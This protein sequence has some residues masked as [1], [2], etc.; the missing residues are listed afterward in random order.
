MSVGAAVTLH[1]AFALA[2]S[3]ALAP[4]QA[5]PLDAARAARIDDYVIAFG[6][7]S[8]LAFSIGLDDAGK[9][10]SLSYG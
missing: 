8:R 6:P 3:L 9:L 2:F 1:R 7:G 5:A 4:A 10:A